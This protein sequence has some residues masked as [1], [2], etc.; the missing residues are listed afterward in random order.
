MIKLYWGWGR[1]RISL[2]ICEELDWFQSNGWP[3]D[4]ACRDALRK[5]ESLGILSLPPRGLVDHNLFG[6]KN[7]PVQKHYS[8]KSFTRRSCKCGPFRAVLA[9]GDNTE[10]AWNM[11]VQQHHYLGHTVCVGRNL[12]F[13]VYRED[14]V[15]AAFSLSE[16]S[17]NVGSRDKLLKM[18]GIS[19]N[20]V[21]NNSRFLLLREH[22]RQN[23]ASQILKLMEQC[24]SDIWNP[25]YATT[26]KL[27][28]T[29]VDE[30]LFL[31][32]CYKAANWRRIGRTKG[33]RKRG[34]SFSNGQSPKLVFIKPLQKTIAKSIRS[35]TFL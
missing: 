19:R 28:E 27:F 18:L 7:D 14:T 23:D 17:Y 11:I 13:L 6:H 20:E 26:A 34:P 29:F 33:Y 32:T 2:K 21:V 24:I 31:G 15:V 9:K 12:K 8:R 35:L 5:M 30:E 3:K 10:R 22:S 4:R 25:F 1:W 16:A